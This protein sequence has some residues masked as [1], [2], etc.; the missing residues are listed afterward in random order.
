[1]LTSPFR[2]SL[3]EM[4]EEQHIDACN[5][6]AYMRRITLYQYN[7]E[8]EIHLFDIA[9]LPTTRIFSTATKSFNF[10][11]GTK[12]PSRMPYAY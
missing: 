1:M 12:S 2:G 6:Y 4:L 9:L 7:I 11:R 5:I 8:I 10:P 3:I